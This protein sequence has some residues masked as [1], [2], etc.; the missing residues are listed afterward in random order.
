MKTNVLREDYSP[1]K[2]ILLKTQTF[3]ILLFIKSLLNNNR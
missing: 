2:E 1:I 3:E